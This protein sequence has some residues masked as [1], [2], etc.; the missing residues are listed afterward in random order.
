MK[1][2]RALVQVLRAMLTDP[3]AVRW[4]YDLMQATGLRSGTLYPILT[5][6]EDEGYLTAEWASADEPG[7]RRRFYT[8]T[9]SGERFGRSVTDGREG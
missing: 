3:K 7:A 5:R 2:T 8:L 6:L 4:G 9:E 1:I